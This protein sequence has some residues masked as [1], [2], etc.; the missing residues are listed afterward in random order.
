MFVG[1]KINHIRIH[2]YV[3]LPRSGRL[4]D[5]TYP[6]RLDDELKRLEPARKAVS[7]AA[8]ASRK[9]KQ[10]K[11]TAHAR[12]KKALIRQKRLKRKAENQ[13]KYAFLQA[14]KETKREANYNNRQQDPPL[15]PEV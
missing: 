1:Y 3:E 9:A 4:P 8:V 10:G 7:E 14:A 5:T 11:E 15:S 2:F 13:L 12:E 6:V